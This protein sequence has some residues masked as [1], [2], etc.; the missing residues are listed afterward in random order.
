MI[1]SVLRK[2]LKT[3]ITLRFVFSMLSAVFQGSLLIPSEFSVDLLKAIKA[4]IKSITIKYNVITFKDLIS[5]VRL[6]L[7]GT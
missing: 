6:G 1:L 2:V 3:L 5:Q 7:R 4:I